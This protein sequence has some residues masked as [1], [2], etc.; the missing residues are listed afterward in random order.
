MSDVPRWIASLALSKD[1][2]YSEL[3]LTH[4]EFLGVSQS[5]SW[6]SLTA[7]QLNFET[8]QLIQPHAAAAVDVD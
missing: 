1:T 4:S 6:C 5:F 7:L 8:V 3:L 2:G